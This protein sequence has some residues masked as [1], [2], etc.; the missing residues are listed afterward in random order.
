MTTP[1]TVE[2]NEQPVHRSFRLTRPGSVA[3]QSQVR[4]A[5]ILPD[6]HARSLLAA[7]G[8]QDIAHGGC[9]SAGP[10]G[11]QLWSGPW[12]GTGGTSRGTAKHLGSVDWG[13][14]TPV[15]R[16]VTIYRV[17]VTAGGVNAGETS[18]SVLQRV[19]NL[20][21]Q[22]LQDEQI[23]FMPPRPRDPFEGRTQLAG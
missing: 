21:G 12:D 11:V 2:L 7:A 1:Y 22:A 16:Y 8:R 13:W 20:C 10:A 14:D 5:L 18:E 15:Q 6:R 4:P 19:M 9:F 3:R 23:G 17:F